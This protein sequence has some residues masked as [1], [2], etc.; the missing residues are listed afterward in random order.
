MMSTCALSQGRNKGL[1]FSCLLLLLLLFCFVFFFVYFDL[2]VNS[3]KYWQKELSITG[4]L[5]T[6]VELFFFYTFRELLYWRKALLQSLVMHF[7]ELHSQ[8]KE[9]PP[10]SYILANTCA[11]HRKPKHWRRTRIKADGYFLFFLRLHPVLRCPSDLLIS[12]L[13]RLGK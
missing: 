8:L 10:H 3:V 13:H 1:L 9:F 6:C 11:L 12:N 4:P 5:F 2:S 7:I